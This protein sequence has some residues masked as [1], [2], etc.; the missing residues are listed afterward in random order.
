M[1]S[2][3]LLEKNAGRIRHSGGA[4]SDYIVVRFPANDLR[5]IDINHR[6]AQAKLRDIAQFCHF[7]ALT[8]GAV[9][10]IIV[11]FLL[12]EQDHPVEDVFPGVLPVTED[13]ET[14]TSANSFI[15]YTMRQL[16]RHGWV[17]YTDGNWLAQVPVHNPLHRHAQVVLR[18]LVGDQRLY[19]EPG[20][21]RALPHQIDFAE[22]PIDYLKQLTP[23]G[24]CGA[25]S[26]LV[27]SQ[28]P[29]L[30]FNSTFFLLE[31]E[32]YISHH[33][34]LG[35]GFN[36]WVGEGVIRRP[37]L[38]RRA[39]IFGDE[40]NHWRVGMLS[41]AD[42]TVTLP[43]GI[44][45]LPPGD[46]DS[47]SGWRAALNVSPAS[48]VVLYT[49]YFGVV[50][51][52]RVLGSTP[53]AP[54]RFELTIVD[55]RVVG[56]KIGGGLEIPQNGFVVSFAPEV[57]S[58]QD[59]TAL[60]DTLRRDI[61]VHYEFARP[62]HQG[63]RE[64]LQ[65]GPLLLLDGKSQLESRDIETSEQFWASRVLSDGN[66]QIGVVPT[67]YDSDL[68][69]RH[70]RVGLGIG[71][72]GEMILVVVAGVS[73]GVGIPGLESQGASL[74]ELTELL[75]KAGARHAINLDGGGSA[76]VYYLGGRAVIPAE[77][78][79]QSLVHYDRMVPSVGMVL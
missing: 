14:L 78:R 5:F 39:A 76:Q 51:H 24:R 1:T 38:Y 70:A 50:P 77:R 23:I 79:G 26:D 33:S 4:F 75:Q 11:S 18:R 65:A 3:I 52:G 21:Q 37:P 30:A 19:I 7:R 73:K 2:P 20:F 61:S 60:I 66:Y 32:D 56:W 45:L 54:E 69:S 22:T 43:G 57:M 27:Y 12:L 72:L 35:E 64:A 6:D 53:L 10:P 42:L 58:S 47:P 29:R 59:R 15:T 34:S 49:R 31:Y 40:H 13:G 68:H 67:D 8:R 28:H 48:E 74:L 36:L 62:E 41:L 55:R 71:A 16:F 9:D 17:R 44:R 46:T 25:L 63:I